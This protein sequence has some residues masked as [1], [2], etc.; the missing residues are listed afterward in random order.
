MFSDADLTYV[1][2]NFD[3]PDLPSEDALH[4]LGYLK[5]DISDIKTYYIRL[6]FHLDE[7]RRFGY[8]EDFGFSDLYEFC[9]SNLGLDKSAVSRCINVWS[10]F[11]RVDGYTRTMFLDDRYSNYSYSQLCEMLSLTSDQRKRVL[12][13]MTIKDIRDFKK[14]KSGSQQSGDST[15]ATSQPVKKTFDYDKYC[16]LQGAARQSYIKSCDPIDMISVDLVDSS[17]RPV[18]VCYNLWLDLLEYSKKDNRIV[19]RLTHDLRNM[20]VVE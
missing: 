11:C 12:P 1:M 19:I 14:S 15:V 2:G 8:Y 4:S 18:D 7:F 13:D 9:A 5:R 16:N 10:N 6:G 3:P 20:E 17:G